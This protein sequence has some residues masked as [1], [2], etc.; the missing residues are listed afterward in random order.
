MTLAQPKRKI[1]IAIPVKKLKKKR[2]YRILFWVSLLINVA[3]AAL[4]LCK[5]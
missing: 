3:L 4:L 5:A 2:D 1:P